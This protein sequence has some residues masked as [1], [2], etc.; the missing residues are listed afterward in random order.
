MKT[1]IAKS[2][3]KYQKLD[4]LLKLVSDICDIKISTLK[5]KVRHRNVVD[6]RRIYSVIARKYFAFTL[7]EIAA[8][9]R[10]DHASVL[11]HLK[12]HEALLNFD[13]IYTHFFNL[14]E[15]TVSETEIIQNNDK[16]NFIDALVAEN[17]MLRNEVDTLSEL[18]S[19]IKIKLNEVNEEA[20]TQ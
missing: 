18:L 8:V 10:R 4:I 6:A 1:K 12:T 20:N 2:L 15:H 9:I 3:A 11:H 14:C 7:G 5:S 17:R 19:N 13:D 16:V